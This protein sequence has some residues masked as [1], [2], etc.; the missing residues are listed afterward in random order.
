MNNTPTNDQLRKFITQYFSVSELETFCFD[1]FPEVADEVAPEMPK[2][3]RVKLLIGYCQRREL[4]VNLLGNLEKERPQPYQQTFATTVAAPTISLKPTKRNPRQ[5]F[6]SHAHQDAELAQRLATDLE[7]EGY[8]VW[9]APDS[10]LPG[11]KWATAVSRGLDESGIFVLLL[12]PEAVNSRWVRSETDV[13][14][15]ME[16]EDD[17]RLIPL[18]VKPC[19]LPALWRAYQRIAWRSGYETGLTQLIQAITGKKQE[20]IATSAARIEVVAERVLKLG[21]TP[22]LQT[23][24]FMHEKTGLEFVRIPAGDFLY[25][26]DKKTLNLPDYWMSK[27]P[28]TQK[29]YQRF[30]AANPAY[31][32]PYRTEGWAKPYNWDKKKRTFPADK[33]DH[34]VVLVTWH[35]AVAFAEWAKLRLPTEQEWEKASRGTDGREYPWGKDWHENH[36]NTEE[37]GLGKTSSVG[38][39]SPQGDSPYG[40]VDMSG[41]VWDWTA[42]LYKSDSESR[43]LRG[44]S[45]FGSQWFARVGRRYFNHPSGRFNHFGFRLV[46]PV[47]GS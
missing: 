14:V 30:I 9:I 39:Y 19:R 12:T 41:N 23:N 26:D 40:C 17:M 18:Q 1:Y 13:A 33:A 15:E 34:P 4:V 43:V 24:S 27:T 5:I 6:I 22:P 32:V 16:H 42:S 11:E 29:I 31:D 45:W 38:S 7:A 20:P 3:T 35:D 2:S 36:C 25:G 37:V 8:P 10:I 21:V 46:A 28:V 47:S 44:G